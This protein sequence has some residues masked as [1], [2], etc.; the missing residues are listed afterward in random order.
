MIGLCEEVGMRSFTADLLDCIVTY[1]THADAVVC[2]EDSGEF[3]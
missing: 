3:A 1:E 2:I